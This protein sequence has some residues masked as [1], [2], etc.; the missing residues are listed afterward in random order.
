MKR[1]LVRACL[2]LL[3]ATRTEEISIN[4]ADKWIHKPEAEQQEHLRRFRIEKG[5]RRK[6]RQLVAAHLAKDSVSKTDECVFTASDL[7]RLLNQLTDMTPQQLDELGSI[8]INLIAG[9]G[10]AIFVTEELMSR[11]LK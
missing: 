2:S 3:E 11:M 6:A 4:L 7:A 9:P 1:I 8:E 10:R 5:I